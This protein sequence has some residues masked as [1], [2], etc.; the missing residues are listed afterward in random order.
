MCVFILSCRAHQF[1]YVSTRACSWDHGCDNN[2]DEAAETEDAAAAADIDGG[3]QT[4]TLFWFDE[5]VFEHT[6]LLGDEG[7]DPLYA[8]GTAATAR[9]LQVVEGTFRTEEST[10]ISLHD[11]D[12]HHVDAE[13]QKQREETRDVAFDVVPAA[14]PVPEQRDVPVVTFCQ[15]TPVVASP[16]NVSVEGEHLVDSTLLLVAFSH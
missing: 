12:D 10:R 4:D 1:F 7:K 9:C 6:T 11:L 13:Q 14:V 8:P 2:C 16:E 3:R 5:A 15:E